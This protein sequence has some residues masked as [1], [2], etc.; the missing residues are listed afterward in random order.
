[1]TWNIPD[2]GAVL[3]LLRPS[4][5]LGFALEPRVTEMEMILS[6]INHHLKNKKSF[7]VPPEIEVEQEEK[8]WSLITTKRYFIK[9]GLIIRVHQEKLEDESKSNQAINDG[10]FQWLVLFNDILLL[11][12]LPN[13]DYDHQLLHIISVRELLTLQELTSTMPQPS[14]PSRDNFRHSF[15][16]LTFS[17]TFSSPTYGIRLIFRNDLILQF[18]CLTLSEQ[19]SW[20]EKFKDMV[21]TNSK[22]STSPTSSLYLEEQLRAQK[23]TQEYKE[24]HLGDKHIENNNLSIGISHSFITPSSSSSNTVVSKRNNSVDGR[25]STDGRKSSTGGQSSRGSSTSIS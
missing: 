24:K 15:S 22:R 25:D 10:S 17:S 14:S 1:M 13:R 12:T 21:Y 9:E 3:G 8:D 20:S 7:I 18:L 6:R 19:R 4:S 11:T 23:L 5:A 2:M 16:S